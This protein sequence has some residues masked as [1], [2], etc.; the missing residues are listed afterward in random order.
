MKILDLY[1][2]CGGSSKGLSNNGENEV[3][4]VDIK[5][6]HYYPFEFIHKNVLE[7]DV[8]F[9]KKFDLIWASP[10]Y[11]QFSLA[12]QRWLNSGYDMPPNLIPQTRELLLK[13]KVPYIIENV[14]NAPLRKDLL[15]CGEMFSGLRILRHRIFEFGNG[16]RHSPRLKHN[17]HK[18]RLDKNH[19]YYCQ[20]AGHGG[21]SYSYKLEDWQDAMKINW[22]RN[23]KHMVEMIPPAY[24]QYIV[25]KHNRLF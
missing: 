25:S 19:T 20:I 2:C 14:P 10:P 15:L 7:L 1:C 23:K 16:F 18:D 22:V 4:G 5:D 9:L 3:I 6:D 12:S 13:S 11:Q 17:K 21:E 8:E 24:S